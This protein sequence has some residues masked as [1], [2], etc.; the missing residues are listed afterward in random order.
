MKER[1]ERSV[2]VERLERIEPFIVD[3][4]RRQRASAGKVFQE[5]DYL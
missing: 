4:P 1:V 2:A 3:L 5:I